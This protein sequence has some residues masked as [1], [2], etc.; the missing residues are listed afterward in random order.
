MQI[1]RNTDELLPCHCGFKPDHYSIG[2]SRAP[3][4]VNC[5][6]CRKL[7]SGVGG[8]SENI[9]DWWNDHGRHARRD[10]CLPDL[11]WGPPGGRFPISTTR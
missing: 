6:S 8:P 2:Y 9:I 1:D 10:V 4:Y 11:Q 7:L 3:Y 5:M